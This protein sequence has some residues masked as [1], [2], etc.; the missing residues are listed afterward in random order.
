M[1]LP[2]NDAIAARRRG[3]KVMARLSGK[4]VLISGATSGIGRAAALL[5]AAEGASLVLAGRRREEGEALAE[6]IRSNGGRAVF[7]VA[8]ATKLEDNEALVALALRQFDRL[9]VAFNNAGLES[10]G[11]LIEFD[12]ALY[13]R[14]FDTNVKGVLFAIRAQI[15]ALTKTRGS[16]IVTSSI[17]GSRGFPHASVYAASKHAV[18]G[19]VKSAALELAPV[20]IRVNAVAPGPTDTP[21][22]G[23]FTGGHP[24]VMAAR[25]PLGRNGTPEEIA[26]AALW[27]ATD[28]ARFVNGAIVPVDGGLAA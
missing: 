23:R 16:I 28:D 3:V 9:D 25:V 6:S 24:E 12:E 7:H 13:T 18:E 19:I 20:G 27:L 11:S 21:M 8:D 2:R 5:F 26:H 15:P 22:L 4:V 1:F 14:V 17:A 10:T